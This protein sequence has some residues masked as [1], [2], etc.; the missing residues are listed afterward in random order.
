MY[1]EIDEVRVAIA[2][3]EEARAR[4]RKRRELVAKLEARVGVYRERLVSERQ[5]VE[6][7]EGP[8]LA[9]FVRGLLVDRDHELDRERRELAM[10]A[11]LHDEARAELSAAREGLDDLIAAAQDTKTLRSRLEV[12]LRERAATAGG[13]EPDDARE[14]KRIELGKQRKELVEAE[15]A[16]GSASASLADV[17]GKLGAASTLGVLDLIGGGMMI[18]MLKHGRIGAAQSRLSIAQG[19][20]RALAR[21]LEDLRLDPIAEIDLE[22][23]TRFVDVFIDNVFTDWAVQSRI[24]RSTEQVREVKHRVDELQ[25][26][27]RDRLRAVDRELG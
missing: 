20:L 11:V 5:D 19:R 27:L 22:P 8:G 2:A 24:Q 17:L 4:L 18:S 23:L 14:L 6:R 13:L 15:L 25:L 10:A 1:D 26:V 7:L 16:A 9:A 12:L 21:E 3:A